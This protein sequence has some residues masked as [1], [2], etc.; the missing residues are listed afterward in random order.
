MM[1]II[2][3][4]DECN[5]KFRGQLKVLPYSTYMILYLVKNERKGKERIKVDSS[6]IWK[7]CTTNKE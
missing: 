1:K 7:K 4:E 5:T 3:K 2:V 6:L